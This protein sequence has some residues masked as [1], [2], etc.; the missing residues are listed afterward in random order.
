MSTSKAPRNAYGLAVLSLI[1][2]LNYLDRY[3]VAGILLRIEADF[4]IAHESAGLI[5]TVF[6]VV[7]MV[8]SPL[9]GYLGDRYPRKYLI[10][11]SVFLWSIATV[12]SGLAESFTALLIARAITGIGEAGYGTVAPAVIS[13]RGSL[14][15]ASRVLRRRRPRIAR[16]GSCAFFEGAQARRFRCRRELGADPLPRGNSGAFSERIVLGEH[17]RPDADDLFDWRPGQ[18]DARVSRE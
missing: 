11:G 6:V 14:L 12:F 8:F 10:A 3:I 7:Y 18:L 15:L 13:D 4:G 9:G 5:T 17:H 2:F 16:R 1:N